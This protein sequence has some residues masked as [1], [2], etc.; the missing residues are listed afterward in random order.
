MKEDI[1]KLSSP[2]EKFIAKIDL[3]T[4]LIV[5]VVYLQTRSCNCNI[6]NFEYTGTLIL[7]MDWTF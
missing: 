5:Q 3:A 2:L 4:F 1:Q 7:K 6:V